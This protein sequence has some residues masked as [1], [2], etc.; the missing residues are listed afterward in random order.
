VRGIDEKEAQ[1]SCSNVADSLTLQRAKL[2]AL[3]FELEDEKKFVS[4]NR[5]A[6]NF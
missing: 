6:S 2:I 3:V 4:S 1:F 5:M